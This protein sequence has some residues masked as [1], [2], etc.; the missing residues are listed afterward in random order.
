[1]KRVPLVLPVLA[2][3]LLATWGSSGAAAPDLHLLA[4]TLYSSAIRA[5]VE[6]DRLYV[7]SG[8]T[9]L[10]YDVTDPLAPR[11]EAAYRTN[12]EIYGIAVRD[13]TAYL[14]AM[15]EGVLIVDCDAPDG[16]EEVGRI[17]NPEGGVALS[18]CPVGDTV[19]VA[20]GAAGLLIADCRDPSDPVI[21]SVTNPYTLVVS[22]ATDVDV[23]GTTAYVTFGATGFCALTLFDCSDPTDPQWL[24]H[25]GTG[26]VTS[27]YRVFVTPDSV[28][29]VANGQ[30]L[31]GVGQSWHLLAFDCSDPTDIQRV[32]YYGSD[33]AGAV[34]MGVVVQGPFVYL[35]CGYL[36]DMVRGGDTWYPN[37]LVFLRDEFGDEAQPVGAIMTR[38]YAMDVAVR[39]PA[40]YVPDEWAG[41]QVVD[42]SQPSSPT[43]VRTLDTGGY[44]TEVA[45]AGSRAYVAAEGAGVRIVDLSDPSGPVEL[46]PWETPG[47]TQSVF[48]WGRRLYVGEGFDFVRELP[49]VSI[50]DISGESPSLLG[51]Y[52]APGDTTFYR[53]L[54]VRGDTIYAACGTHGLRILDA[55]DPANVTEVAFRDVPGRCFGIALDGS[56]VYLAAREGG[57]RIWDVSDPSDPQETGSWLAPDTVLA[58]AVRAETAYVACDAAGVAILDC[59][60]P[61]A[62]SLVGD[63][64]PTTKALGVAVR[65]QRLY[66]ADGTSG[67]RVFDISDPTRPVP[68]DSLDTAGLACGVAV[69]ADTVFVADITGGLYLVRDIGSSGSPTPP[70]PPGRRPVIHLGAGPNPFRTRTDILLEL[71][72]ATAPRVRVTIHDLSGRRLR[73]LVVRPTRAGL[74]RV[75][76]DGRERNGRDVPPGVYY[77]RVEAGGETYSGRIVRMR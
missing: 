51:R 70:R 22:W 64:I 52:Q 32:G 59:R 42:V 26:V 19:Y 8:A 13:G 12:G 67:L 57:L 23:L 36:S 74:V 66:V 2:A 48:V 35:A 24:N 69:R 4:Q 30:G 28:A 40:A 53:D 39:P 15:T 3:L 47:N 31:H 20:A 49:G 54:V 7:G 60:D 27:S 6:G 45:L 65:G 73:E 71:E 50:L 61:S 44:P 76:W 1:V 68:L 62:P 56:R 33:G 38:N 55:T 77:Y 21:L 75:G 5:T 46:P 34:G 58:V 16:P 41:V 17:E 18:V 72:E 9:L 29:W 43:I 14:A 25:A 63:L 10:I 37:F 11:F